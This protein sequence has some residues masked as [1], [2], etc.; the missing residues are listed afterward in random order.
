MMNLKNLI[1]GLLISLAACTSQRPKKSLSK[2]ELFIQDLNWKIKIPDSLIAVNV[3]QWE[4]VQDAG[5][6]AI[7]ETYNTELKN[8]TTIRFIFKSNDNSIF[9][10]AVTEP[11]SKNKVENYSQVCERMNDIAYNTLK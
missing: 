5:K 11:I 3:E 2:N 6:Q 10:E 7:S 4:K 1:L 8:K 9:F